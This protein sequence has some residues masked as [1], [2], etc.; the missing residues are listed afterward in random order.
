MDAAQLEGGVL[1]LAATPIGNLRDITLR[2]LDALRQADLVA[3]EDTRHT[4]ELL[5]AHGIHARLLSYRE[6]N[7]AKA[8]GEILDALGR[9][10]K[11]VLVSDAGTP[12]ISDPGE[13]LVARVVERGFRVSPLP[14]P[15]A[16]IAALCASGLVARRFLF[17]GFPPRKESELKSHLRALAAEPGT[18]VFYEAGRR[19]PATLAAAAE[20]LG[21]RRAV[22][23]R[24][25]TKLH[26]ELVR[27][28][29]PELCRRF[30]DP[31]PG[32]VVLLVEGSL[33]GPPAPPSRPEIEK[34]ISALRAGRR[35]GS[36]ECA[37]L[38][39]RLLPVPRREIY[40]LAAEAGEDETDDPGRD[41]E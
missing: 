14:G 23:A 19:L 33:E 40:R 36:A 22:V 1:Y 32:E 39:S 5:A 30:A 9:G 13:A 12:G 18:L 4:R 31:P 7:H 10:L 41:H 11:V 28:P 38:L 3:A 2:V 25:L 34:L 16:A 29:L 35:M 27:G 37:A 20:I 21:P 26:E 6:Q 15:S 24:E 17:V 8:S